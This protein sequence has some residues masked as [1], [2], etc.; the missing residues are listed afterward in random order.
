M[1][2]RRRFGSP[3]E[4]VMI[5]DQIDR[6]VEQSKLAGYVTAY[7]P[8]GFNPAW[9][10]D[11]QITADYVITSFEQVVPIMRASGGNSDRGEG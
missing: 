4:P 5:G 3:K 1:D 9:T 2:L 8:G 10:H 6:D 11:R 7:F